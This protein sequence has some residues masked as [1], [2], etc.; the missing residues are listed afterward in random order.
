MGSGESLTGM[1]QLHGAGDGT[2]TA[3]KELQLATLKQ[4]VRELQ[5][6]KEILTRERDRLKMLSPHTT[7]KSKAAQLMEDDE[8]SL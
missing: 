3:G 4:Q 6:E 1:L 5:L 7:G 8:F 2:Q